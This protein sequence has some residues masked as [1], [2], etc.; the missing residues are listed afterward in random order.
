MYVETLSAGSSPT[1]DAYDSGRSAY[2]SHAD[3]RSVH[4]R[5]QRAISRSQSYVTFRHTA[6]ADNSSLGS[7]T[8]GHVYEVTSEGLRAVSFGNVSYSIDGSRGQ[9][10]NLD[11]SGRYTISALPT[12]SRIRLTVNSPS[13]QQTCAVYRGLRGSRYRS[14]HQAGAVGHARRDLWRRNTVR[15]G[16]TTSLPGAETR[17]TRAAVRAPENAESPLAD[18]RSPRYDVAS[19]FPLVS[20]IAIASSGSG[21]VATQTSGSRM[22]RICS[23]LLFSVLQVG[24]GP[25]H[26]DD[27]FAALTE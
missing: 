23:R 4:I 18:G 26:A 21:Q 2:S 10:V 22:I 20:A 11:T 15:R 27:L 17:R 25:C 3:T 8:V 19:K 13:L 6:T 16:C 12:G 1:D 14:A 7:D 24:L 5:L 9:F